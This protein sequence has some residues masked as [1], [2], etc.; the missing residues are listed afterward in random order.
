[1][2]ISQRRKRQAVRYGW[3]DENVQR[4][5][6][7]K[8]RGPCSGQGEPEGWAGARVVTGQGWGGRPGLPAEVWSGE[9]V[10][11]LIDV[12]AVLPG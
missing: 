5:E 1:M 8:V 3:R 6:G 10:V 12:P 11:A 2:S 7:V 4:P 9:M